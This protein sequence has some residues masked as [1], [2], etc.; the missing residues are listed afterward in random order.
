[1]SSRPHQKIGMEN[2]VSAAPISTWST[3]VPRR[4]RGDHAGRNAEDDGEQHGGRA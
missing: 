4:S 3:I 2:P 1:M